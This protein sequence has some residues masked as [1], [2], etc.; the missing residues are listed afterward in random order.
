MTKEVD[1]WC[2]TEVIGHGS[3]ATVWKA[4]HKETKKQA[5]V[6][7]INTER[8]NKKLLESL[9]SEISVLQ[10]VSHPHIVNLYE[11]IKRPEKS[12]IYLVL[13]YCSGGDLSR[14]VK[15]NG[16][17]DEERALYLMRQLCSGLKHLRSLNLMH[18]D[19][20]P[21][22]LLLSKA[23]DT[24]EEKGKT[25]LKI[26]DFGFARDLSIHGLADTLCGSPLYMAPEILQYKQYDVKADLWSVGAILF[27]LVSG[28]PPYTGANH[29]QLLKS[30]EQKEARLPEDLQLSIACRHLIKSLLKKNPI[31][32]LSFEGLFSHPFVTGDTSQPLASDQLR[33]GQFQP[34]TSIRGGISYAAGG[35]QNQKVGMHHHHHHGSSPPG[36]GARKGE[37][38][39]TPTGKGQRRKFSGSLERSNQDSPQCSS[40]EK[41]YVLIESPGPNQGGA[42][43]G[44]GSGNSPSQSLSQ[45]SKRS[46]SLSVK[47]GSRLSL[48]STDM[49]RQY[50]VKS[51]LKGSDSGPSTP[52]ANFNLPIHRPENNLERILLLEK[53]ATIIDTQASNQEDTGNSFTLYLF[54]AK[55]LE[56]C[57]RMIQTELASKT[58]QEESTSEDIDID[59][60]EFQ[61]STLS[62]ME[63]QLV[64]AQTLAET[65]LIPT[66]SSHNNTIPDP[67]DLIYNEALEMARK[68]AVE[69]IMG[70]FSAGAESYFC[71]LNLLFFICTEAKEISFDPPLSLNQ[72][73]QARVYNYILTIQERYT[74]CAQNI[75]KD[76][77]TSQSKDSTSQ[78]QS[79]TG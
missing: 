12:R 44:G 61:K 42:S 53:C 74:S 13:E 72:A 38:M 73:E 58:V 68:G 6:K 59:F 11:T 47:T 31:Q 9:A 55:L 57:C 65:K 51:T 49:F 39:G 70:N 43:G 28:V 15:K 4:Y 23:P 33:K 16:R 7:E 10:R 60:G 46:S 32:R 75:Q 50:A 21:Q 36:G 35:L 76:S 71:A 37:E 20:K 27:E 19:L 30:I 5:A 78:S 45:Q 25:I 18:R 41:E 2:L 64:K 67:L 62:K 34:S 17:L 24:S 1:S 3:F 69:E 77:T 63:D 14:Y 29:I 52:K 48:G 8:L 40:L 54:S 66:D 79:T 56:C 26:A 22:N